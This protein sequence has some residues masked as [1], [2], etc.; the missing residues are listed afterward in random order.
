MS[1]K[2]DA[3][4][5]GVDPGTLARWERG[6]GEPTGASLENVTRFF[7]AGRRHGIAFAAPVSN[8]LVC[9]SASLRTEKST[10]FPRRSG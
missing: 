5:I 7:T 8:V 4:Q 10:T 6:Q 2:E 3:A 9:S 1:Q